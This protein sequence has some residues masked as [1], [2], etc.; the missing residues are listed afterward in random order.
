MSLFRL[1]TRPSLRWLLDTRK[2]KPT[3]N[4]LY[5]RSC[6]PLRVR[7]LVNLHFPYQT[8]HSMTEIFSG[9]LNQVVQSLHSTLAAAR[10]YT[11]LRPPFPVLDIKL[12]QREIRQRELKVRGQA[13]PK[14]NSFW[15][16][17]LTITI[18]QTTIF[19][20]SRSSLG[21]LCVQRSQL[22]PQTPD[23]PFSVWNSQL[24]PGL[25]CKSTEHNQG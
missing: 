14:M 22:S 3:L 13:T 6:L 23:T 25:D 20:L 17:L 16:L 8:N 18:N 9:F 5:A 15:A 4:Y 7:H 10:E 21:Q 19:H 2:A 1:D 11:G 24:F 12:R